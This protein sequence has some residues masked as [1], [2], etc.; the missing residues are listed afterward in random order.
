MISGRIVLLATLAS[1]LFGLAAAQSAEPTKMPGPAPVPRR[2]HA[3]E[4]NT[5]CEACH[6]DIAAEWRASLHKKAHDDPAY[7]R[8]LAIEPLPFCRGCHAPEA[9]PMRDPP[10]E[11]GSLGVACT[12]CHGDLSRVLAAPQNTGRSA[13]HPVVRDAAFAS[14]SACA[15]CHEFSFPDPDRRFAPL[16]MQSTASEHRASPFAGQSC[17][18]CHMPLVGEGASKHRSHR[19]PAS[20]D[21]ALLRAAA[22]ITAT[23]PSAGTVEVHIEPRALGHAF[24]TGDLFRRLAVRAEAVGAEQSVLSEDV[25]YLSRRFGRGKGRDGRSIKVLTGDDRVMPGAPSV[26][27]LSLGEN[28]DGAPIHWQVAYER[29]EHP[30]EE[31]SDQAVVEGEVVLAE[32]TLAPP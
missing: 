22:R 24:P 15:N 31:N 1:G 26:V 12:S 9:D 18:E 32:G 7:Q 14:A 5:R 20:R 21:P 11:L 10:P 25:R 19:F 8:A 27:T 17:A 30:I 3:A 28:A 4:E 16:F 13:P 29:V 2:A 6:A 23:R